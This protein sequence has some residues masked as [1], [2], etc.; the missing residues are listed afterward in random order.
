MP[1]NWKSPAI[2]LDL[3]CFLTTCTLYNVTFRVQS[4]PSCAIVVFRL[5]RTICRAPQISG[6]CFQITILG[7]KLSLGLL[8]IV[9]SKLVGDFVTSCF[10]TFT[11]QKKNTYQRSF[12]SKFTNERSL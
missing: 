8:N 3:T 4:G 12:F 5:I 11:I 2:E 1:R 7:F 6:L 9:E 10:Q